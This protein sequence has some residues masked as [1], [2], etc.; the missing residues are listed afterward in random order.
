MYL[1]TILK[2]VTNDLNVD[3][4]KPYSNAG[5]SV[6]VNSLGTLKAPSG[7]GLSGVFYQSH[8]EVVDP[9]VCE[10]MKSFFSAKNSS[11]RN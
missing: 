6:V 2:I 4:T 11:Y 7:D 1:N 3:L 8:W 5:I 10:V 9:S